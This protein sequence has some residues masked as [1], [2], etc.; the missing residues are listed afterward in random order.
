MTMTMQTETLLAR[1]AEMISAG[2]TGAARP[3]LAAARD[4]LAPA[5]RLAE[6]F[7]LLEM[8]DGNDE[9][10]R[11]EL[12][13][14]VA[15]APEHAGLRKLRAELRMRMQDLTGAL[16]DAAASVIQDARDPVAKALLGAL[17]LEAGQPADAL[18]CL[19]EAVATQPNH[20]GFCQAMAA[21][22]EA[23]G[24]PEQ[25]AE[26]LATA[27]KL[28]PGSLAL[29]NAA[30]LLAIRQR[31]FERAVAVAEA[32]RRDG[33]A[34][35]S[36]FVL[37]GHARANMGQHDAAAASYQEALK[38]SPDDPAVRQVAAAAG[39]LPGVARAP[40]DYVRTLF[41]DYAPR[42]EGHLVGLGDRV[43]GLIRAALLR[44]RPALRPAPDEGASSGPICGPVL[45]LG[46]GT[47][48]MATVLGDLRLHDLVGVD[49]SDRM[50]DVARAKD[51]YAELHAAEICAFLAGEKR[52]F[53]LIL[54]ADVL[55]Y[56]GA[57]EDPLARIAARL[58][59]G[60]LCIASLE[61]IFL[62][63]AAPAE[64]L[65]MDGDVEWVLGRQGRYAHRAD[66]VA[67]CALQAGLT[68]REVM[69]ETLRQE[70]DGALGGLVVVLERSAT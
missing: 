60:G 48:L 62:D 40:A 7:A 6:L 41:D 33:T 53:A 10:A 67:Q 26:T 19:R 15:V 63:A 51:V 29:R 50:L 56:F 44:H 64:G 20:A 16:D 55:C 39:I 12:D 24:Q 46:C 28:A 21:A 8:R 14:G 4:M 11:V 35:A 58:A 47:G 22:Q 34:N 37:L 68:L 65:S 3:V 13:R 31:A 32:A 70:G 36:I 27:I 43:P 69:P 30:M 5:P 59:P 23:L 38:L 17:L 2:R 45:D 61:E 57:L 66:Y 49:L 18:I 54:A 25:A 52:N 1:A 42:F 9:A